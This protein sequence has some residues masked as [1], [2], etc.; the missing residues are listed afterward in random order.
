MARPVSRLSQTL[1]DYGDVGS[2]TGGEKSTWQAWMTTLT[3]GN[4]VAQLG[5][6]SA[7]YSA[8]LDITVGAQAASSVLAVSTQ[9]AVNVTDPTAQRENKWLVRYH[10][11]DSTKFSLEVP[12]ADLTL[13][14]QGSEFLNLA[15]GGVIA[16]FKT[17]FEAVVKSPDDPTLAVT[18]DSMQYVGRR[19]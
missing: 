2:G 4:I 10:D 15:D 19:N 1:Q 11:A 12:T 6:V 17:A 16:A 3:A 7:L 13:L 5:L 9:S 14:D 18:I 8:T